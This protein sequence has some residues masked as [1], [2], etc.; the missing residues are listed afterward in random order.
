MLP[1]I[2]RVAAL[3]DPSTGASQVSA[4]ERAAQALKLELQIVEVRRRQ[5]LTHAFRLAQASGVEAL[6]V[7]SSPFL[8]SVIHEIINLSAAE[9]LPTVYSGRNTWKPAA[10]YLM[11]Q[12]LRQPGDRRQRWWRKYSMAVSRPI[13]QSSNQ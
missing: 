10:S 12:V 9:R 3:W 2:R 4:T 11:G 8:A 7:F 13:S 5:D 6:S 1:R